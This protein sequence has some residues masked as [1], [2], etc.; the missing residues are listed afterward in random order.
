MPGFGRNAALTLIAAAGLTAQEQ[1]LR[2]AARLDAEGKCD[3]AEGIYQRELARGAPSAA[4][5]N[6]AGN[7]AL[8]CGQPDRARQNFLALL[9]ISPLHQNA[10]LQMAR[11]SVESKQ[12]EAA[13]R[14]LAR[15]RE[16]G[17]AV[18]LIRA[19]ALHRAGKPKE[20][21]ASLAAVQAGAQGDPRVL[22]TLGLTAARMGLYTRAVE[23]F[24]EVAAKVPGNVDVLL[25]LGRAVY[26]AGDP[27]RAVFALAQARK[28][29]PNNPDILLPLAQASEDAGFHGD[30]VTAYGEYL[31]VRPDD[32]QARL[33]RAR[34][35]AL[36]AG[37]REAGLKELREYVGKRPADAAG[38]FALA[39]VIWDAQPDEAL[40]QLS[41]TVKL[42]PGF[43]PAYFGR[44][45]LLQRMGRMEESLPDLEAAARLAPKDA[46]ALDQLGVTYLALDRPA[47]AEKTLR[48]ALALAPG[49]RSVLMHLGR[50]LMALNR[51]TEA[52][53]YFAKFRTAPAEHVRD[54]RKEP[55]M[56]ALA[57]LPAAEQARIQIARLRKDAAAYPSQPELQLRLSQL[58]LAE[59]RRGE[60]AEAFRELES[61]NAGVVI[62]E[63]AG[64]SLFDAGEYEQAAV[65]LRRAADGSPQARRLLAVAL[66][67]GAGPDDALHVLDRTPA[68]ERDGD[69]FIVRARALEAAG[70]EG[71]AGEAVDSGMPRISSDPRVARQAALLLV[72]LG[73]QAEALAPLERAVR[74]RPASAELTLLRAAVL[75]LLNRWREADRAFREVE[76]R[77]PEWGAAYSAHGLMLIASG[78][79]EEAK[80]KF[81]VALTLDSRDAFARCGV[82]KIDG[83]EIEGLDCACRSQMR[84]L[85]LPACERP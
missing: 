49:D 30:A 78:E 81:A 20:A 44:A 28:L 68:Q 63:E 58:L 38:R 2:E 26:R 84:Q 54:P 21:E 64:L 61:R 37:S 13:L 9:K 14:Y 53:Q 25:N 33:S 80:R 48:A 52:Q 56:I 1:A 85:L 62:W 8:M 24:D 75:S 32:E 45:W 17:A 4:L 36:N 29:A 76:A 67:Y 27:T 72:S 74:A 35:L 83:V 39:Q 66:L 51:E 16:G 3:Q 41:Q 50:A 18:A 71:E 65:F 40:A 12:G 43:A 11:L 82:A 60:A 47:E 55:G 77:W 79:K 42:D 69:W 70:K 59:G 22:F 19:E 5:L 34:L 46:R 31:A 73:R 15:V 10:N 6:N 23:A 7:H 57:T